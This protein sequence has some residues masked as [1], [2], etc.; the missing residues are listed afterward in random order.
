[1]EVVYLVLIGTGGE[2]DRIALNVKDPDDCSREVL[3][4]MTRERW[5]LSVGDRIE[6]Q[7]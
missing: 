6:V 5:V 4:A 2:L 1:M 7:R 3:A